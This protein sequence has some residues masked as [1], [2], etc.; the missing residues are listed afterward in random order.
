MN[1]IKPTFY[2]AARDRMP[3]G[4]R[5]SPFTDRS[6]WLG[7]GELTFAV[8]NG[9]P[10][11]VGHTLVLPRDF[12]TYRFTDL[13]RDELVEHFRMFKT[14][15][16]AFNAHFKPDGYNVGWNI[17]FHG[18]QSIA[19]AHMHIMPRYNA[20]N[21]THKINPLGGL[22]R[23]PFHTIPD[24]Y[25]HAT[26][27]TQRGLEK[28]VTTMMPLVARNDLAYAVNLPRDV[29]VAQG[30][31]VVLPH[32]HRKSLLDCSEG[33]FLAQ[34]ELALEI[35]AMQQAGTTPPDGY[36]IGWDVGR[37]GGQMMDRAYLHVLPRYAGDMD[38]PRGGIVRL[39]PQAA[40]PN[41][42]DYYDAK[43]VGKDV[44]LKD[45]VTFPFD[46]WDSPARSNVMDLKPV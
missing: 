11:T 33:E 32:A 30:H 45:I 43:N 29:A 22:V 6:D 1:P 16:A 27:S 2:N 41:S 3:E 17:G 18:G 39:I 7:Q 28:N 25:N 40:W 38:S 10:S 14:L 37:A 4:M 9:F 15:T 20:V 35:M 31:S 8:S 36:N 23:M 21:R 34:L 13:A 19:H 5:P 42:T 26:K 44:V 24:F 46:F 12:G